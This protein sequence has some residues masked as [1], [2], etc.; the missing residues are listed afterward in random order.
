MLSMLVNVWKPFHAQ[1]CTAMALPADITQD[2]PTLSSE[3][4]SRVRPF[5]NLVD[6]L[7]DIGLDRDVSLP[8]IVVLGD[9]SSGKSSVLEAISGVQLPRG[10]GEYMSQVMSN[11][12]VVGDCYIQLNG[13]RICRIHYW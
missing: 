3:F 12:G 7:R 1:Q 5:I 8:T 11:I 4:E 10:T 6:R 13:I 9:Q 2:T